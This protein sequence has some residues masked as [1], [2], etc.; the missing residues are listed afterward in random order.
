MYWYGLDVDLWKTWVFFAKFNLPH[1]VYNLHIIFNG[2]RIIILFYQWWSSVYHHCWFKI[3]SSETNMMIIWYIL[4]LIRLHTYERAYVYYIYIYK[5]FSGLHTKCVK[6][7]V[8][9]FFVTSITNK[10]TPEK[11]AGTISIGFLWKH[12]VSEL[13]NV[14]QSSILSCNVIHSWVIIKVGT[15]HFTIIY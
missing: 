8:G 2:F 14:I 11:M 15:R 6:A 13:F 4:Q 1:K 3:I 12:V 10:N 5:L 9:S 7:I